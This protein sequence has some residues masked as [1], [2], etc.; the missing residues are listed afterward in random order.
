MSPSSPVMTARIVFTSQGCE[1]EMSF[2]GKA[3]RAGLS[4]GE[5]LINI[6]MCVCEQVSSPSRGPSA[7]FTP[8]SDS[9]RPS[10]YLE[11]LMFPF[12]T[13]GSRF[14]VRLVFVSTLS[15]E[16]R[17]ARPGRMAKQ[18]PSHICLQSPK[19]LAGSTVPTPPP[20]VH[21]LLQGQEWARTGA[22]APPRLGPCPAQ[23][24]ELPAFQMRSPPSD[25][26]S[27]TLGRNALS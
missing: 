4:G 25:P 22:T 23:P 8:V 10:S 13:H 20:R 1:R 16:G 3:L 21:S 19:H 6:A 9:L 11:S 24:W 14:F 18:S 5:F 7:W 26:G 15:P 2:A 27:G 12:H 17:D